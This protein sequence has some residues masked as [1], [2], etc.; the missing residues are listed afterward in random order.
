MKIR[1][2]QA[3]FPYMSCRTGALFRRRRM[4]DRI[5]MDTATKDP[6]RL[7]LYPLMVAT[8]YLCLIN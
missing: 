1:E 3:E 8:T 4:T 7:F 6:A 2:V 5:V